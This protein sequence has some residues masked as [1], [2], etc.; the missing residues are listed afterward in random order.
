MTRKTPRD[1]AGHRAQG[2]TKALHCPS[3]GGQQCCQHNL[4]VHISHPYPRCQL[5]PS[6]SSLNHLSCKGQ[7]QRCCSTFP[8]R[9]SCTDTAQTHSSLRSFVVTS[10]HLPK[11]VPLL[12]DGIRVPAA[13]LESV[14]YFMKF[15]LAATSLFSFLKPSN[16]YLLV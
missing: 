8:N 16:H 6:A 14:K 11:A 4:A 12:L 15:I 1:Q 13:A 5:L 10:F 9:P 7:L 2:R 3:L